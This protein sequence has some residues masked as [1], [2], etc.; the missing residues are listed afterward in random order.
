MLTTPSFSENLPQNSLLTRSDHFSGSG[1]S[2]NI[3]GSSNNLA[4]PDNQPGASNSKDSGGSYRTPKN[5]RNLL[6]L[7]DS[8]HAATSD[9]SQ[10]AMKLFATSPPDGAAFPDNYLRLVQN[11]F[12]L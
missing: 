8:E 1:S 3:G 11:M 10:E 5:V 4:A 12:D 2:T 7:D 6:F 9:E